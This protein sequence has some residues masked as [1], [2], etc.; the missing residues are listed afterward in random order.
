[1]TV[2]SVYVFSPMVV[3]TVLFLVVKTLLVGAPFIILIFILCIYLK[4]F[5]AILY[6][7]LLSCQ[8][9]YLCQSES[10]LL[11]RSGS[12][13]LMCVYVA[14]VLL[15]TAFSFSQLIKLHSYVREREDGTLGVV[16]GFIAQVSSTITYVYVNF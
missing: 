10:S 3:F 9:Y 2:F 4:I 14:V 1:M 6:Y 13:S 7:I 16:Q 5:L 12:S 11:L 8:V 15:Y